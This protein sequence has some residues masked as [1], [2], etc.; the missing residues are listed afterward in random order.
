[1]LD[2][3]LDFYS[4]L[5]RVSENGNDGFKSALKTLIQQAFEVKDLR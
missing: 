1:M 2:A 3:R 5:T 4:V